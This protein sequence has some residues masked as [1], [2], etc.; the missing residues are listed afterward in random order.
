MKLFTPAN[1]WK[2]FLILLAAVSLSATSHVA[3]ARMTSGKWDGIIGK[4]VLNYQGIKLGTV[5]DSVL[6]V[7]NGRFVGM[8][9]RSRTWLGLGGRTVLVPA[10]AIRELDGTRNLYVNMTKARF[11]QAPAMELSKVQGPPSAQALSDLFAYFGQTPYFT[12][13]TTAVPTSAGQR[14]QLGYIQRTS[15]IIGLPVDNMQ[16]VRM[17]QIAGVRGL[18]NVTG[19]LTGIVIQPLGSLVGGDMKIVQAHG[20]R[21]SNDH[22]RLRMNNQEQEFVNAP[23]FLM[24][25]SGNFT[26][27]SPERPGMPLPP[28]V[29]GRSKRDQAITTAIKDRIAGDSQLSNYGKTIS[30][31]TVRGKTIVRGRVVITEARDRIIGYAQQAAGAGN[32]TAQI[33]VRRMSTN[34]AATD[35]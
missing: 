1:L 7:E 2:Q 24:S 15:Q 27:A 33:E 21:Y 28:L 6:D 3:T 11:R 16:G 4:D 20:L 14:E 35:L 17:G 29:Q 9:V 30:V 13:T 26:E 23:D 5:A 18:N 12:T 19:R 8:L 31:G 25:Q 34:E 32:V 22:S 10:G